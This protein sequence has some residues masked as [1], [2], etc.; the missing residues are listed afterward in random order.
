MTFSEF[1]ELYAR[2]PR[3]Q[4]LQHTIEKERVNSIHIK[5]LSAS[6]FAIIASILIEKD[7]FPYLFIL[8]DL[9][10]AGYFYQDIKQI[11]G[12]GK[13]LFYPSIICFIS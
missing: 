9:E 6:S 12:E 11:V 10:E 5:G 8:D 1:K 7:S 2:H 3:L 4:A 13:V